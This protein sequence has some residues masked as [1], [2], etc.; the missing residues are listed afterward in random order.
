MERIS[1]TA[2]YNAYGVINYQANFEGAFVFPVVETS[3]SGRTGQSLPVL[4]ETPIISSELTVTNLPGSAKTLFYNAVPNGATSTSRAW[5]YGLQQATESRGNLALVNTG[6][7][8]ASTDVFTLDIYNGTTGTKAFTIEGISVRARRWLQI[9]SMLA[10][11]APGVS[12]GY[13]QVRR[14]S[15]NNPFMAHAVINDGGQPGERS[16]DGAL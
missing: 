10:L 3:L 14:T 4:A 8:D 11:H 9:N 7:T 15:G 6:E 1:G 12:Q 5:L 13:A 2:P 16:G